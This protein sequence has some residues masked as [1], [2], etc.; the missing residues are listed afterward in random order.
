[1]AEKGK[2]PISGAG[3]GGP[4]AGQGFDAIWLDMS[5]IV[6]PTRDGIHGREYISTSVDLGRKLPFLHLGAGGIV[7][8]IPALLELPIPVLFNPFPFPTTHRAPVQAVAQA[9][10]TLR[11][12]AILTPDQW[13]EDVRAHEEALAVRLAVHDL[14][15]YE[16]LWQRAR[17]LELEG[18]DAFAA[19]R[20]RAARPDAVIGWYVPLG[21]VDGAAVE[22]MVRAGA[23]VIHLYADEYGQ[24]HLGVGLPLAGYR[25]VAGHR[26]GGVGK[27]EALRVSRLFACSRL[28]FFG[29]IKCCNHDPL[30]PAAAPAPAR[31]VQPVARRHPPGQPSLGGRAGRRGKGVSPRRPG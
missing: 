11:T 29:T 5:E 16:S 3:Y 19:A 4:F 23:D 18:G 9:A 26:R 30:R 17:Y 24:R 22:Q 8:S 15:R 13:G 27:R 14:D 28:P 21:S 2:I 6:R 7:D 10:H 20:L 31:T 25:R 1:M 12:L